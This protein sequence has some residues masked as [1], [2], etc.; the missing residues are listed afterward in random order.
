MRKA[1][2]YGVVAVTLAAAPASAQSLTDF[3][4]TA[5]LDPLAQSPVVLNLEAQSTSKTAQSD[6]NAFDDFFLING[7]GK[8]VVN[9]DKSLQS[10]GQVTTPGWIGV[11]RYSNHDITADLQ[12]GLQQV[13]TH[14]KMPNAKAANVVIYKTIN[15]EQLVYDYSIQPVPTAQRCQEYLFTPV[16]HGF[17][18]G[19]MSNC[20]WTLEGFKRP[21]RMSGGKLENSRGRAGSL[22]CLGRLRSGGA[23]LQAPPQRGQ[24][25]VGGRLIKHAV[26]RHTAGEGCRVARLLYFEGIEAGAD[27]KTELVAQ[28]IAGRP[29]CAAETQA[30]AQQSRLT[31]GTAVAKFRKIER[32]Q[33]EVTKPRL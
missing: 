22:H 21:L 5:N 8:L 1:F 17:Q 26:A 30:L 4:K 23:L 24:P 28:N 27:E 12:N 14:Y 15:T 16:N 33:C 25:A 7:P 3:F 19:M 20:F 29:Q 6:L 9:F 13:L 32:N 10:K 18:R 31:V 2:L 11:A